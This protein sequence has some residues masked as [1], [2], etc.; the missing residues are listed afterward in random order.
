MKKIII[1]MFVYVLLIEL[2]VPQADQQ[3]PVCPG[4][5]PDPTYTELDPKPARYSGFG[6]PGEP[7]TQWPEE[8]DY[9]LTDKGAEITYHDRGQLYTNACPNG[10]DYWFEE[11][12][13]V[14]HAAPKCWTLDR[15]QISVCP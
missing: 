5:P 6:L 14:M 10:I 1:G 9:K 4:H 2:A 12:Q 8:K 13:W 15:V 3:Q 7:L 11:D